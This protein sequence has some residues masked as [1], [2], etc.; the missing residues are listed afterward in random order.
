MHG[1]CEMQMLNF[2]IFAANVPKWLLTSFV[3]LYRNIWLP[4][5]KDYLGFRN[6][7][8]LSGI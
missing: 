3:T 8:A 2:I 5:L 1:V 4:K 7:R 6:E